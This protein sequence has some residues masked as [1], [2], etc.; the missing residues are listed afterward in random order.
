[1]LRQPS[2]RTVVRRTALSIA[3]LSATI[4][5]IATA[6]GFRHVIEMDSWLYRHPLLSAFSGTL[7]VWFMSL[8][9][10]VARR[11]KPRMW[12]VFEILAGCALVWNAIAVAVRQPPIQPAENAFHAEF[13]L[14][15]LL[16]TLLMLE[17]HKDYE[18][19]PRHSGP[20]D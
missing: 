10:S 8:G 12:G 3:V 17:G 19:I 13:L 5:G 20:P 6:F 18:G 15:L 1:M 14:K 11:E 7:I 2:A 4:L 9:M 16:A